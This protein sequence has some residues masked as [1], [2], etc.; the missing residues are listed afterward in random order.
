VVGIEIAVD[1]QGARGALAV[2]P[3]VP[4]DIGV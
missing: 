4:D 1:A 3:E 2:L